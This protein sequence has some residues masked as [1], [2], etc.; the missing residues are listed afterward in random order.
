VRPTDAPGFGLEQKSELQ[1]AISM[2]CRS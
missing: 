2:I 1:P